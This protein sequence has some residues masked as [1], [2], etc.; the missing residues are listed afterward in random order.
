M[1]ALTHITFSL[2]TTSGTFSLAAAPLHR[3]LPAAGAAVLGSLLPDLDSP[4]STLGR[5]VP[6]LSASLE[7]WRH[8]TVTHSLLALA[9]L[10]LLCLPLGWALPSAYAGLVLGYASHLFADCATV[11]GVMLFWPS[12][13][14]CVIPGSARCRIEVGSLA[15]SILLVLLLALLAL[16]LPMSAAGGTWRAIRYLMATPQGAY[17]TY[18]EITSEAL[19]D[20]RGRWRHS[21]EEVVARAPILEATPS[22]FTIAYNGRALTYGAQGHILPGRTRVRATERP[23]RREKLAVSRQDWT[24]LLASIPADAWVSGELKTDRPFI[25]RSSHVGQHSHRPSV[26]SVPSAS[27]IRSSV[28]GAAPDLI[29]GLTVSP[30]RLDLELQFVPRRH[31]DRLRPVPL[32]DPDRLRQLTHRLVQAERKLSSLRVRRPPVHYL[33]LRA[34]EQE[35]ADLAG[36]RADLT[37]PTVL[38]TG[39]LRLRRLEVDP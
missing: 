24:T 26:P 33:E 21:H 28:D 1:R 36:E 29:P 38:F 37:Q 25:D 19:L 39:D 30:S 7:R 22:S 16:S 15:E 5:L 12:P 3:D 13:R 27:T 20:F 17:S 4:H 9:V 6:G 14:A 32:I 2:L 34:A 8:R 10:S 23:V 11:S 18:T 31:L 35:L